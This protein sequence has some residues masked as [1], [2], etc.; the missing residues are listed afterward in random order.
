LSTVYLADPKT[1]AI[2]CRL[3]PHPPHAHDPS[4]RPRNHPPKGP[5]QEARAP[6]SSPCP[7]SRAN[8]PNAI[9]Y[10]MDS[11]ADQRVRGC[12]AINNN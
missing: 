8:T 9:Q 1:G 4:S 6:G 12:N 3:Y 7:R 10:G 11:C 5:I 2:L